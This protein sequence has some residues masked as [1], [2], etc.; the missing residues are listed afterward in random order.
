[1]RF[2]SITAFALAT[3]FSTVAIADDWVATKL[4]G[5]VLTLVAGDWVKLTRGDVVSDDRVI[6]TLKGGRVTFKRGAETIDL[7]GDTQVQIIDRTGRKFTTVKQYFGSVAVEADVRQVQHF[8]VQTPHL[9]AVVKGTRFVVVSGKSGAKVEVRRG[10]VAVEDRDTHQSTLVSAGQA[11]STSD[12][13]PLT[14][15]GRGDLPVVLGANGR[16][17]ELRTAKETRRGDVAIAADAARA[18]AIA[19]GATPKEAEKAAREAAKEAKDE[20]KEAAKE[21]KSEAKSSGNSE[22]DNSGNTSSDNSGSS[23]GA[24][25]NSGNGNGGKKD[26]D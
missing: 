19:A 18:G 8:S 9:A 23:S 10:R 15:S 20:A 24:S 16:P 1:M 3:L 2:L 14:V 4:R 17:V 13:A 12:G 7:G 5:P 11:V 26:K 22:S 6:R 21:A 25:D